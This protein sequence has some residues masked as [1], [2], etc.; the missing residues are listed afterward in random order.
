MSNLSIIILAAG[1]SS[2]LGT[3]KQLLKLN[4]KTLLESIT[5]TALQLSSDVTVVLGKYYDECCEMIK[6]LDVNIVKN[7]NFETGMGS[8]IATGVSA[9]AS[10]NS[11]LILLCD[12]PLIPLKHY[13]KMIERYKQEPNQIVASSYALKLAVPAIFPNRYKKELMKLHGDKGAKNIISNNSTVG[14][15]LDK[16]YAKDIDTK[17]NYEEIQALM[18]ELSSKL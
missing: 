17:E 15:V 3:P 13:K 12:Q 1:S 2:R 16:K 7:E 5:T 11:F 9:V 14:V 18:T 8:S 4:N 10:S 6:H